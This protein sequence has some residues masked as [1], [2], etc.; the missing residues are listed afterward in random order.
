MT[1][2][3]LSPEEMTI[4]RRLKDDFPHYAAKC[5]K[6]RPKKGGLIP[7]D[8]NRVQR[9]IHERLQRQIKQT[10]KVRALILKARQPGCSTYVEGRFYW[11]V[12]HRSGVRAFIL[13]HKQEAT[14]A[15]FE[16]AHRFHTKCPVLVRP[17]TSRASAK[18]L[19]FDRLD[20]GYRVS[21]AGAEAVGRG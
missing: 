20:S 4:R 3:K 17:H 5:L 11:K 14:D 1:T 13:C 19:H 21:T 15:I 9:H 6:I 10:G 12:T 16:M 18:E 7:L 2:V 8:L